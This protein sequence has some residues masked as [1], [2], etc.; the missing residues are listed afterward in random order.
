M[1]LTCR[2]CTENPRVGGQRWCRPCHASYMREWRQAAPAR[3]IRP[4]KAE[5]LRG[6]VQKLA[7]GCLAPGESARL[8]REACI[9]MGWHT[10]GGPKEQISREISPP[11]A[12]DAPLTG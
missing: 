10:P 2:R 9:L 4:H 3:G 11:I 12:P 6:I 5:K 7:A 1:T 8:A